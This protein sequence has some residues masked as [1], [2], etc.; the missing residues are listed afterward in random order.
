MKKSL[1]FLL[2]GLM[3]VSFTKSFVNAQE[4]AVEPAQAETVMQKSGGIDGVTLA[5]I[6]AIIAIV[7]SG[8]G[9]ARGITLAAAPAT[10]I[11]SENPDMFGKLLILVTLP[12]TQGIYGF[13]TGFLVLLKIGI[14]GGA[15]QPVTLNQGVQILGICAFQSFI[16]LSSAIY[17]GKVAAHGIVMTGKKPEASMK[18]VI[19][20]VLVETYAVL[21]LLAGILGIWFGIRF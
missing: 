6:G 10:G 12:G 13:V 3:L 4:S 5:V 8:F 9:S 19:M 7:F 17:Q 16:E 15:I 18:G 11:M 20:A 2:I 21:G 1:C 14:I